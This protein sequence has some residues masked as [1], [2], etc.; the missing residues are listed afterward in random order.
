MLPCFRSSSFLLNWLMSHFKLLQVTYVTDQWNLL[1]LRLNPIQISSVP[2]EASDDSRIIFTSSGNR[3][4]V[5]KALASKS[6][7]TPRLG[8]TPADYVQWGFLI[9]VALRARTCTSHLL[10]WSVKFSRNT[11]MFWIAVHGKVTTEKCKDPFLFLMSMFRV[12]QMLL[13]V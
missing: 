6:L 7:G 5:V 1:A 8:S 3:G 11:W 4:R 13:Y 10:K 2:S 12:F 9:V